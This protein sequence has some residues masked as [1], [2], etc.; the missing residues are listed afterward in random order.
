[1][2]SLTHEIKPLDFLV[3]KHNWDKYIGWWTKSKKKTKILR[4]IRQKVANF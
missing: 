4:Q 2:K 3:G 1:M